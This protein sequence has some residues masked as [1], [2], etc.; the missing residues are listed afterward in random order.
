MH[1]ASVDARVF[2]DDLQ[3]GRERQGCAPRR[4]AHSELRGLG[5]RRRPV[6]PHVAARARRC[7]RP[8]FE[9]RSPRGRPAQQR[10][11]LDNRPV[12]VAGVPLPSVGA[13]YYETFVLAELDRTLRV[14]RTALLAGGALAIVFGGLL[15]F[16]MSRR[17][18]RPVTEI[19]VAARRVASGD[20]RT[21]LARDADP[22][23]DSLATSFNEMVDSVEQQDPARD[24]IRRRCEPRAP[25]AADDPG[26][27]RRGPAGPTHRSSRAGPLRVRPPRHRDR[28]TGTARSRTFWSSAE[29]MPESTSWTSER[30]S[31]ASSCATRSI[32]STRTAP[33]S[34]STT[35]LLRTEC[36]STSAGSNGSLANL[37]ANAE[38][39]GR[40]THADLRHPRRRD[41][42]DRGRR[43]TG[44]A[45][46]CRSGMPSSLASSAARHRA[47]GST[48][49]GSGL[50][51]ALVAEHVSLHGGEVSIEDASPAGGARF[52][53]ELPWRE[54]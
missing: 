31:S 50:G 46:T 27:D 17:V 14:I 53:V 16:W 20:F 18:L 41:D 42:A 38:T 6:V 3:R 23:L 51:L 32:R 49:P 44:R 22:D 35:S 26:D 12:F 4:R 34:S 5:I 9:P 29:R 39:H 30:W 11:R 48:T 8:R 1:Q 45:S 13:D 2:R 25:I 43:P 21:R 28:T 36:S 10:F 33:S 54:P 15:G 7:P 19:A 37:V 24:P 40:R 52:V 47:S